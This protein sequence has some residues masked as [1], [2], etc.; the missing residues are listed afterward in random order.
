MFLRITAIILLL[1]S[2]LLLPWW[3]GLIFAIGLTFFFKSFLEII[4]IY[5]FSDLIFGTPQ[6][7]FLGFA[8]IGTIAAFLIY[9]LMNSFKKY[10]RQ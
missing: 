3:L 1:F 6:A 8:F 2:A 9:I 5:F 10:L 4:P 7:R